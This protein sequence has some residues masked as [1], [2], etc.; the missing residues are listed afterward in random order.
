[1]EETLPALQ[2]LKEQGLIRFIGFT[3]LPLKIYRSVLDRCAQG[4]CMLGAM[5]LIH[6]GMRGAGQPYSF[7]CASL[8]IPSVCLAAALQRRDHALMAKVA[9]CLAACF[10]RSLSSFTER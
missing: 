4:A 8:Y 10:E 5:C 9:A 6:E 3:G 7:A 1:M 2:K